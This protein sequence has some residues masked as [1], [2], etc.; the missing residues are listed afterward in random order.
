MKLLCKLFG[1]KWKNIIKPKECIVLKNKITK[2]Y[3]QVIGRKCSR[4]DINDRNFRIMM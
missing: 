4:C 3:N 2:E 1:H